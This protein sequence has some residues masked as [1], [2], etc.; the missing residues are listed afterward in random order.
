MKVTSFWTETNGCFRGLVYHILL[1]KPL[2]QFLPP[3]SPPSRSPGFPRMEMA[4][5]CGPDLDQPNPLH[6]KGHTNNVAQIHR[7]DNIVLLL[8]NRRSQCT[9]EGLPRILEFQWNVHNSITLQL[10]RAS[11]RSLILEC[12]Y[13]LLK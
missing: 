10:K 13:F 2:P 5:L 3:Q 12:Y 4:T 9:C 6:K 7:R 1:V 8:F 11:W